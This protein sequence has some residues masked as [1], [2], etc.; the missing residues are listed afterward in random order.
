MT[1]PPGPPVRLTRPQSQVFQNRS[2]FRV[3]VA[4]RRFGKTYLAVPELLRMAWA[5]DKEA[6]YVAPTYKQ[7]KR[8]AWRQLKKKV[9]PY[10]ARKDETDLSIDLIW[11]ARICLRG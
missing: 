6:W 7:A 9:A 8:I 4:G 1:V 3:L 5:P 11:G 2:R 10:I